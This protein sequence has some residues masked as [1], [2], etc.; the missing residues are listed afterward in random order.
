M[1]RKI[2]KVWTELGSPSKYLKIGADFCPKII[3][4]CDYS[5]TV[6]KPV[7]VIHTIRGLTVLH[8]FSLLPKCNG[9]K[10]FSAKAST[11]MSPSCMFAVKKNCPVH[12]YRNPCLT[13]KYPGA[14]FD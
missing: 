1:S 2:T 13:L 8:H 14:T 3:K 5:V 6:I 12:S 9:N 10:Y 4:L 11:H 7:H